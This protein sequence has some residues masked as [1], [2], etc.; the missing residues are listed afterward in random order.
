M[1]SITD[2]EDELR[3]AATRHGDF[4]VKVLRVFEWV[5]AEAQ[6]MGD[7]KPFSLSYRLGEIYG[8]L[9]A[10]KSELFADEEE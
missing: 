2:L 6:G 9:Q 7:D 5:I 3:L 4:R 1:A 10:A 8:Y